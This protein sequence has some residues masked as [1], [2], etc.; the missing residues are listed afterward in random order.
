MASE[1]SLNLSTL[2]VSKRKK[3]V[4]RFMN[5]LSDC[6]LRAWQA[7]Y[8]LH[9]VSQMMEIKILRGRRNFLVIKGGKVSKP[10][11]TYTRTPPPGGHAA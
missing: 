2:P 10:I 5:S 9:N 7:W 1:A 3:I 4:A 6:E 11:R 8:P